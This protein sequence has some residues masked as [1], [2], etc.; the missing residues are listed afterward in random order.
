MAQQNRAR[1]IVGRPMTPDLLV[2]T[3]GLN[4]FP[5]T[6]VEFDPGGA[7]VNRYRIHTCHGYFEDANKDVGVLRLERIPEPGG[8]EFTLRI[9]QRIVNDD[10]RTHIMEALARCK[11]DELASPAEWRLMNWFEDLRGTKMAEM[12]REESGRVEANAAT[13][14]HGKNEQTLR[15]G[16]ARPLTSDWSLFA[17]VQRLSFGEVKAPVFDLL[18]GMSLLREEHRLGYRG[19][20]RIEAR[21]RPPMH[22]YQQIGRGTLP[23][24]YWLDDR[25]RLLAVATHARAYILDDDPDERVRKRLQDIRERRARRRDA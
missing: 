1:T 5:E 22:W 23:Y 9:R 12:E 13:I 10:G 25:H 19:L 17:A 24:E 21:K 8:E 15:R 16:G 3:G 14:I 2:L 18:E 7:W 11:E 20:Y 4:S 6:P